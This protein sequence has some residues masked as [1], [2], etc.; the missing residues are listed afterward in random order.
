MKVFYEKEIDSGL[1]GSKLVIQCQIRTQSISGPRIPI[2]EVPNKYIE[3]AIIR[4]KQKI[5][6]VKEKK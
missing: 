1:N 6:T 4:L 2:K 5:L 3:L